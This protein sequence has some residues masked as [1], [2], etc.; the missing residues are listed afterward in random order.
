MRGFPYQGYWGNEAFSAKVDERIRKMV[1]V[2]MSN[3]MEGLK[4]RFMELSRPDEDGVYRDGAGKRE[5][6]TQL[7]VS[8]LKRLWDEAC[9]D[10]SFDVP[11]HGIGLAA[12]GSLARRQIGPSSDLDL[13]LIYDHHGRR[14]PQRVGE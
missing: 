6:R 7:A 4:R 9:A 11:S 12:V 13:V 3:A 1:T 10:A 2:T 8:C 14:T 5:A